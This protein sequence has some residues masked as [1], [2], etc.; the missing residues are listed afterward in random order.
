MSTGPGSNLG[1]YRIL[2]QIGRGGMAT[3]YR[4]Y[5]PA[6]QRY[7]AIKV[8]PEF[9]AQEPGF[10]E[11]FQQ[12]ATAIARLRHPNILAVFDA[13]EDNGV[14]YIVNEL[15]DGGTLAERLGRPLPL[16]DTVRVLA[17]VAA[18]LDYAHGRGVLHRDVKPSNILLTGD[19]TPILGDFGLAKIIGTLP[20]LTHTGQTVGTPEYMAPEQA[21]GE[22]AG[23]AAD[24]YALAVVAYEMLTGRVP[25]TAET[26]LAVLLAHL[27]RPLPLPR[28][29]NSAL[30]PATETPLLKGL[31]KAPDDRYPTATE[32]VLALGESGEATPAPGAAAVPADLSVK[33]AAAAFPTAPPALAAPEAPHPPGGAGARPLLIGS[34]VGLFLVLAVGALMLV[35]RSHSESPTAAPTSV[36]VSS[37]ARPEGQ[38][39][40]AL[41]PEVPGAP[42]AS[43]LAD[44]A[45][46]SG[47]SAGERP[48][49]E[50]LIPGLAARLGPDELNGEVSGVAV[51]PFA[52]SSNIPN[53]RITYES[54][55]LVIEYSRRTRDDPPGFAIVAGR[56][57]EFKNGAIDVDAQ[58]SGPEASS[59][60]VQFRRFADKPDGYY[61]TVAPRRKLV[62]LSKSVED[63]RTTLGQVQLDAV[64]PNAAN[65]VTIIAEGSDIQVYVNGQPALAV[66]DDSFTHGKIWLGVSLGGE[67]GTGDM[68][69]T[70]ANLRVSK[71]Q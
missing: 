49:L 2:E 40:K 59:F 16:E 69:T 13:G 23:P 43:R 58:M 8:L 34:V 62:A 38:Q 31:A 52:S 3:V 64:Q 17:P 44:A 7:V 50:R 45:P 66:Q 68:R 67:S 32:F 11:R 37:T 30:N 55:V 27:H 39:S 14:A 10:R 4:A 47:V 18:A 54:G 63:L 35:Q 61:L 41:F 15:V 20:R 57:D 9:F 42:P 71:L 21:A 60:S 46:T 28:A 65:R 25:F 24:R 1:P 33:P 36:A 70:F 48:S 5:Q 6:L 22:P 53:S 26:P 19:G 51:P 56:P 29:V 12:E